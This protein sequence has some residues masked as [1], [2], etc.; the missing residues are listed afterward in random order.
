MGVGTLFVGSAV[1]R[2]QRMLK[3]D[4]RFSCLGCF[5]KV[6][7]FENANLMIKIVI[8]NMRACTLLQ[9]HK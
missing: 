2:Q 9:Q 7:R 8:N 4:F 6:V 1:L 3:N 5:V